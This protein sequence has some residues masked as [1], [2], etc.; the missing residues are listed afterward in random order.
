MIHQ[1]SVDLFKRAS[2]ELPAYRKFL[3]EMK[4]DPATVIDTQSF[5]TAPLTSKKT[6]LI[7]NKFQDL[8]WQ[9]DQ[10]GLLLFCAT[11]GSTGEPYYFP[12]NEKLS[13]QYSHL[14]EQ[15]IKQ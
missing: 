5:L 9:K 6:Y 4:F 10:Q 15:Y 1:K 11:S 8:V 3:T 13:W 7:K 12:R 14:I 2:K